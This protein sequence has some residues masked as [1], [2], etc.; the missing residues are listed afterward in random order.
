MLKFTSFIVRLHFVACSLMPG[1]HVLK[2]EH[3]SIILSP[4]FRDVE[5]TYLSEQSE[6]INDKL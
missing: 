6:H 1:Q 2:D 3:Y 4:R 5:P